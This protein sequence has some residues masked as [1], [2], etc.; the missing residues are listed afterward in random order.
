MQEY[1]PQQ[2]IFALSV[3][4]GLADTFTGDVPA[5]EAAL[6]T[7]LK[8][9][10]A[11][12]QPQIGTWELVW[13]PAV[14][15]LPTSNRPD[16]TMFVA[17]SAGQLVVAVAGTNP[18]ALLDWIVE[19]FLVRTQIPWLTGSPLSLDR[20]ISLGTFIGLS[21]LQ[22]MK[23]GAGQPGAGVLLKDFLSTRTGSPVS[24]SVSGHSLGGALSP[25]LALW[26]HDL[27]E[28]WDPHGN[29]TLSSLPSA[30]PTAGNEAFAA[31]L[32]SKIGAQVSRLY[33]PLDVVPH[34][35]MLSTLAE[36]P[37]VYA[38]DIEP[39][40]LMRD[41]AKLAL[42]AAKNG[43]YTQINLSDPPLS[44]S[45]VNTSIIHEL[46]PAFLNFFRQLAYQ[47]TEAYY[48]LMGVSEAMAS[49]FQKIKASA[50]PFGAEEILALI[51]SK[52]AKL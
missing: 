42:D 38:P 2:T 47:H 3:L 28:E 15:E 43:D 5:I 44:G 51:R 1:N 49:V 35:W 39:D 6:T 13:G 8:S 31:Y 30:G 46:E 20:K 18:Y 14:Y 32:D 27:R 36:I 17:S 34:A 48:V 33:N 37:T 4:P 22:T 7:E 16:N 26:L 9:Q 23:P 41:F 21:V 12:L 40:D 50:R 45:S 52:L 19:D 29:A 25:A 24:I 11:R 10:L